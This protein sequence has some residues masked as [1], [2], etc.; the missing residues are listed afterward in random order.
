MLS[1]HGKRERPRG[2]VSSQ[3]VVK[4]YRWQGDMLETEEL[5]QLWDL[6]EEH[7]LIMGVQPVKKIK[8]TQK[9][10]SHG[11]TTGENH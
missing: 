8:I 3:D 10:R 6:F 11:K 1:A 7:T 5:K 4:I 9:W 2:V